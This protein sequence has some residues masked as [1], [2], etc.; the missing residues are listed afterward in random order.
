MDFL[1]KNV[2]NILWKLKDFVTLCS[3][4]NHPPFRYLDITNTSAGWA[5]S[6]LLSPL[7]FSTWVTPFSST[8]GFYE[9]LGYPHLGKSFYTVIFVVVE[10]ERTANQSQPLP[11]PGLG[12]YLPLTWN[13]TRHQMAGYITAFWGHGLSQIS[14]VILDIKINLKYCSYVEATISEG[15]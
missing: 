2:K 12:V 3:S 10:G 5:P 11:G 6:V 1:L 13:S 15:A 9:H 8:H 4:F 7:S 14:E